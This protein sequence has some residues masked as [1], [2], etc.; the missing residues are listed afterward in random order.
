M[1]ELAGE[2]SARTA[3]ELGKLTTRVW[4]PGARP[5]VRAGMVTANL[6]AAFSARV[7]QV[8][9]PSLMRIEPAASAADRTSPLI[10]TPTT[11]PPR[12]TSTA[13]AAMVEVACWTVI[14]TRAVGPGS[15]PSGSLSR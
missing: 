12:R 9:R 11:L 5:R 1:S 8:R 4:R 7:A 3:V 14:T 13:V 6:S 2:R 10:R 15:V